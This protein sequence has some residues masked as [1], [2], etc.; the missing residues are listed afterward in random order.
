MWEFL[1]VSSHY[2]VR[3]YEMTKTSDPK[4]L[5]FHVD[6]VKKGDRVFEDAF[7]GVSRMIFS[8][9]IR[10]VAVKWKTTYQFE[11]NFLFYWKGI[12]KNEKIIGIGNN[13][14]A[15]YLIPP[16]IHQYFRNRILK[17]ICFYIGNV[18]IITF[19][20][21]EITLWVGSCWCRDPPSGYP[22]ACGPEDRS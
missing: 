22:P 1:W 2:L 10:K 9:G 18:L 4:T 14:G 19:S 6:A 3:R 7:Q 21:R 17:K 11:R 12:V 5:V 20:K 16:L 13:P 15:K 8:A